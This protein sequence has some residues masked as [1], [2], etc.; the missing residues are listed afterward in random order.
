MKQ[1]PGTTRERRRP[2]S[3]PTDLTKHPRP[4]K[5]TIDGRP[6]STTDPRQPASALLRL[7]GLDP[8]GYDLAEIRRGHAE[9]KRFDDDDI[10]H[11]EDGDKFVTIRQR[12]E[13]A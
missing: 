2:M 13:V 10:V 8:D 6:F 9:P 3:E 12:A 11:I 5:F 1:H 4:V 7:A